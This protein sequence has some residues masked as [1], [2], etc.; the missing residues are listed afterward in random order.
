M[1]R[2]KLTWQKKLGYAARLHGPR[3]KHLHHDSQCAGSAE[4]LMLTKPNNIIKD[5]YGTICTRPM[6]KNIPLKAALS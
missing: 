2:R 6:K 1:S 5:K 3:Y 4:Q